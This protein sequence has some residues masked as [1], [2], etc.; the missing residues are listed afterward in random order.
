MSN[1]DFHDDDSVV[2]F[3][4]SVGHV[5]PLAQF[6]YG[7]VFR[8]Q[9][10]QRQGEDYYNNLVHRCDRI[11]SLLQVSRR[12]TNQPE[13]E[14]VEDG[15]EYEDRFESFIPREALPPSDGSWMNTSANQSWCIFHGELFRDLL[16]WSTF[17][18]LASANGR[19]IVS[20]VGNNRFYFPFS[21]DFEFELNRHVIDRDNEDFWYEGVFRY[22]ERGS[23]LRYRTRMPLT[24]HA[25]QVLTLAL[26]L[27]HGRVVLFSLDPR[28][29]SNLYSFVFNGLRANAL[30][31]P[32]DPINLRLTG[33]D[34]RKVFVEFH[35]VVWN[36]QFNDLF[37]RCVRMAYAFRDERL[38]FEG[39]YLGRPRSS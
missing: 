36:D 12:E 10:I 26:A 39:R 25:Y 21:P 1:L 22:M 3:V 19:V 4:N 15:H 24:N 38:L 23:V 14:P 13:P 34:I 32:R 35:T 8:P 18:W 11:W 33:S 31:N 2:R 28:Y 16:L 27:L 17:L 9:V 6:D 29:R 20:V 30:V 5:W 37:D 7:R